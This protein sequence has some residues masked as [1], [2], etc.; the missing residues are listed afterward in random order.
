[1]SSGAFNKHISTE[2]IA[3]A[4]QELLKLTDPAGANNLPK[5]LL[6]R[7]GDKIKVS[8]DAPISLDQIRKETNLAA[9]G[10]GY[11][12]IISQGGLANLAKDFST[13][14]ER[15]TLTT[16]AEELLSKDDLYKR[17]VDFVM[18]KYD[19]NS[20]KK[21]QS[22]NYKYTIITTP[23]GPIRI[24][25]S[26]I[27]PNKNVVIFKNLD[28]GK[29]KPVFIEFLSKVTSNTELITFIDKNLDGGHLAGVFNLRIKRIFNLQID[30]SDAANYRNFKVT[31]GTNEDLNN[32]FTRIMLLLN[33]ADYISNNISFDI[34]MVSSIMKDLYSRNP[35][36][37]AELQLSTS[38]QIFG[39]ALSTVGLRLN[40]L[41]SATDR[42][43]P[44]I[45]EFAAKKATDNFIKSLK[46]IAELILATG[47]KL[48]TMGV[49]DQVSKMLVDI[50]SD[51][52][53]VIKLINTPGSDTYVQS[54]GKTAVAKIAGKK[55]PAPQKTKVTKKSTLSG[56]RK[57]ATKKAVLP[58][59][60]SYVN[61]IVS[62]NRLR[63]TSG[64]FYSLASL[65]QLLDA[66]LVLKIKENMGDGSRRDILN[67]RSG[68][69]AESVKV[70]RMSQSREGMITAFY[71]YMKNPYATFST[72]GR[73]EY[74]RTRDPKLLI[75]K[76]IRE[77]A[78]TKVANRLRAVA[79]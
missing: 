61:S 74:P 48:Q 33:D 39:R 37:A 71:T 78:T 25:E 63:T 56:H 26:K 72:G 16:A 62:I 36:V 6:V 57:K 12:S 60:K 54:I 2:I 10:L 29:M 59:K 23:Y 9:G 47:K 1:M 75:S 44:K 65:Q 15:S 38:N 43:R 58:I 14:L 30:T 19:S 79:I 50:I 21:S 27:D 69:F 45:E 52:D 31:A 35:K 17:F 77:I 34:E 42:S 53:Q 73:Q 28:H 40:E 20:A 55:I 49:P 41:I 22:K 13:Y 51:T 66:L 4:R 8:P 76:S 64:Q 24:A 32:T 46:V 5:T 67:L 18:E 11:Q 7:T 70:E 3:R 68:R